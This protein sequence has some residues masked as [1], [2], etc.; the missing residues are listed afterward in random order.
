ML[1]VH[2]TKLDDLIYFYNY[3]LFLL[4]LLNICFLDDNV[5]IFL[6]SQTS[7][8]IHTDQEKLYVCHKNICSVQSMNPLKSSTTTPYNNKLFN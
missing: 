2:V 4:S 1:F 3:R 6:Q 8:P 7:R 5:A